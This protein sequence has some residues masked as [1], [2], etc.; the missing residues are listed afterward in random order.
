MAYGIATP[1][2]RDRRVARWSAAF[3]LGSALAALSQLAGGLDRVAGLYADQPAVAGQQLVVVGQL[4]PAPVGP[5]ELVG[6]ESDERR[7]R[8]V[9]EDGPAGDRHI[10]GADQVAA[11]HRRRVVE[12]GR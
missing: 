6:A 10:P 5:P 3:C 4:E 11:T 2:T 12:P 7:Q 8:R 9:G 1:C